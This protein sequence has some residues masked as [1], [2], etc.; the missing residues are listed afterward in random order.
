MFTEKARTVSQRNPGDIIGVV[1]LHTV[2]GRGDKGL[3]WYYKS[4]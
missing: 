4:G 2:H 1:V 3:G